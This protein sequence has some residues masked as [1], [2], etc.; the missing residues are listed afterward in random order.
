MFDLVFYMQFLRCKLFLICVDFFP[1]LQCIEKM[2]KGCL[3]AE[4]WQEVIRI[5]KKILEEHFERQQKRQELRKDEDY[6]EVVEESLLDEVC[7]VGW[8]S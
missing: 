4:Q 7:Y 3:N 8:R 6:D 2:G 1:Y 5:L